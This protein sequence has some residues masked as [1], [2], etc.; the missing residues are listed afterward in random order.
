M[1]TQEQAAIRRR[2]KRFINADFADS[3][4]LGEKFGAGVR[5]PY[6]L[7]APFGGSYDQDIIT[8]DVGGEN[9]RVRGRID[10]IDK[11]STESGDGL[12]VI[13]YK[14][15]VVKIE[16]EEITRGRNFQMMLYVS[17]VETWGDSAPE[18]AGG[19]FLHVSNQ[20]KSGALVLAE[21]ADVIQQGLTHIGAHLAA[22][23]AGNF[24]VHANKI[25]SD[26]CSHTCDF[27][28][29]CRMAVISRNKPTS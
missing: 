17:A 2:L 9:I 13:D 15:G 3:F 11:I 7:E 8:L 20:S 27:H 26:K 29:F 24:A 4:K 21:N 1:W 22:G 19:V 12:I 6:R 23:R 14:T 10:R 16:N 28:Q 5:T 18:V 25:E